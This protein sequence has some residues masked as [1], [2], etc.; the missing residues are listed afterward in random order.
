MKR[1]DKENLFQ[2]TE[3]IKFLLE[4]LNS[5]LDLYYDNTIERELVSKDK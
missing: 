3:R 1:I 4:E 5:T 2:N